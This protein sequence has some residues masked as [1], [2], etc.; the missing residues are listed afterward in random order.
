MTNST[1]II[2]AIESNEAQE[3]YATGLKLTSTD[4]QLQNGT[5]SLIGTVNKQSVKYLI[6]AS[7]KVF[8]NGF[9]V[10]TVRGAYPLQQYRAGLKAAAQLL[11]NRTA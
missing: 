11:S 5:I 2:S 1:T 4:R 9:L 3:L 8:S 10:R 6:T 7:G